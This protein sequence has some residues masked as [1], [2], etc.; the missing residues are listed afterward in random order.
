MGRAGCY[1]P[2]LEVES[3]DES[4]VNCHKSR[5]EHLFAPCLASSWTFPELRGY[6]IQQSAIKASHRLHTAALSSSQVLNCLLRTTSCHISII[7]SKMPNL[8]F[9]IRSWFYSFPTLPAY[10]KKKVLHQAYVDIIPDEEEEER[11]RRFCQGG[12]GEMCICGI[13]GCP[14]AWPKEFDQEEEERKEEQRQERLRRKQEKMKAVKA[15][16]MRPPAS[17]PKKTVIMQSEA[18]ALE[19][20]QA[21]A[22]ELERGR[23]EAWV[24]MGQG[25]LGWQMERKEDED[26][27]KYEEKEEEECR[28]RW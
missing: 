13:E 17:F 1:F 11:S 2:G 22:R 28:I 21:L 7:N 3:H 26:V 27:R 10:N 23:E 12:S 9:W 15:R 25:V 16:G 6:C 24:V 4:K 5:L 18:E 14:F 20:G 8:E 19:R